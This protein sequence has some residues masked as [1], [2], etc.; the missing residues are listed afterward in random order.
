M[1][2]G[3]GVIYLMA[4]GSFWVQVMGLI[5]S[6]G[7]VPVA[8]MAKRWGVLSFGSVWRLP[9]LMWFSTADW[10]LHAV[11]AA[12]CVL[13]VVLMAGRA[14]LACTIGLWVLWLSIVNA[15]GVF[16]SYQWD[17]L[18]L[19]A[20]FLLI[21]LSPV[22]WRLSVPGADAARPSRVKIWLVRWLVF[23]L[24]FSSGVVKLTSGDPTWRDFSAMSYHY[25]TQPIPNRVAWW[26]SQLPGWVHQ[27]EVGAMFCVELIVPWLI[28][29]PVIGL[30]VRFDRWGAELPR[31]LW[32]AVA[33]V[34]D[35]RVAHAVAFTAISGLMLMIAATGNY[36]FFNWLTILLCVSLLDDGQLRAIGRGVRRVWRAVTRRSA[37]DVAIRPVAARFAPTAALAREMTA[38]DHVYRRAAVIPVAFVVAMMSTVIML[39]TLRVAPRY[40]SRSEVEAMAARRQIDLPEDQ[41]VPYGFFYWPTRVTMGMREAG[42]FHVVNGYGLFAVMTTSRPELIVQGS[43]DGRTW[44]DYEFAY[45][46]GDTRRAPPFVAPHQPRLDWQMWFE[47]LNAERGGDPHYWFHLLLQ[48]LLTG[49][50]QVTGLLA[51]DPFAG[52]PPRYVRAVLYQYE[53]TRWGDGDAGEGWWRR[54]RQRVYLG[55][56]SMRP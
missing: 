50:E 17:V 26:M 51:E 29:T 23:R 7:I 16:L 24:I 20:G 46:A 18:L 1:L 19:E 9:T 47:A 6:H 49:D 53:F 2:R 39:D 44:R 14:A 35:F 30:A 43:D 5:G 27:L 4:F 21:F 31:P 33:V 48:R 36:C 37:P 42:A 15:G 45:K 25:W 41:V 52:A 38:I 13:A 10:M 32:W 54:E 28:L 22:R 56:I 3:L 11:C 55:P 34:L 12:G 8:L 40:F